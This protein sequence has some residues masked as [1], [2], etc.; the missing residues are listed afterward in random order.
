MGK[1]KDLFVLAVLLPA[2]Q[3]DFKTV[4]IWANE[5]YSNNMAFE[6]SGLVACE[7]VL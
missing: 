1:K 3:F 2:F 6:Q 7:R 4:I 5:C